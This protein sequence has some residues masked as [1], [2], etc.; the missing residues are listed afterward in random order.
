MNTELFPVLTN[1][2]EVVIKIHFPLPLGYPYVSLPYSFQNSAL[3]SSIQKGFLRLLYL[4]QQFSRP[5]QATKNGDHLE[6]GN[7]RDKSYNCLSV[8]PGASK[9]Q[10]CR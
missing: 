10:M 8:W 6:M 2:D 5:G 1:Y 4:K 7:K 9:H 3:V